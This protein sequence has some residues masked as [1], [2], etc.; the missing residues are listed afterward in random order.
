MN[1]GKRSALSKCGYSMDIPKAYVDLNG[2]TETFYSDL[3]EK[4]QQ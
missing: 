1:R 2:I 3:S 4:L